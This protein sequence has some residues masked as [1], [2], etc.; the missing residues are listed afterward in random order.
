MVT[1]VSHPAA[2]RGTAPHNLKMAFLGRRVLEMHLQMFLLH[3]DAQR[4]ASSKPAIIDTSNAPEEQA[5]TVR[6]IGAEEEA[7]SE[8]T[9]EAESEVDLAESVTGRSLKNRK[10]AVERQANIDRWTVTRGQSKGLGDGTPGKVMDLALSELS[11][12]ESLGE[13]WNVAGVMLYDAGNVSPSLFF[14]LRTH[15]TRSLSCPSRFREKDERSMLLAL[16]S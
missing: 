16:P 9:A 12:G 6:V 8:V 11:L 15:V 4:A 2:Q 13:K 1:H 10:A 7:P 14:Y 3:A 5:G